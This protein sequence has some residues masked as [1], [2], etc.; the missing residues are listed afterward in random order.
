MQLPSVLSLAL[1]LLSPL[2]RSANI[3]VRRIPSY[4]LHHEGL[5][6]TQFQLDSFAEL[7]SRQ[8]KPPPPALNTPA[9]IGA[10]SSFTFLTQGQ[11]SRGSFLQGTCLTL[12]GQ[13]VSS[14]IDLNTCIG[15]S[16]G[17]GTFV[18]EHK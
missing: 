7:R 14:R 9:T 13:M 6:D 18:Y 16:P 12:D 17:N 8:L 11:P 4:P 1:V 15:F 5:K 2:A 3:K 10:C